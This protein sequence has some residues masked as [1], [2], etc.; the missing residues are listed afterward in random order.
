[1][2]SSTRSATTERLHLTVSDLARSRHFYSQILTAIGQHITGDTEDYFCTEQ[3]VISK[4]TP[5]SHPLHLRFVVKDEATL[6][7]FY[8]AALI[9][10]QQHSDQPLSLRKE[11]NQVVQLQDPEGNLVSAVYGAQQPATQPVTG[12]LFT[13]TE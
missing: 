6:Q 9:H 3:V 12:T 10:H 7:R 11:G 1:M 4:G 8:E 2:T 5:P 13:V